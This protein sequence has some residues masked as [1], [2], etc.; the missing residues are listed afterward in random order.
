MDP[1]ANVE[2]VHK[3]YGIYSMTSIPDKTYDAIILAVAHKTFST[4][5]LE[6]LRKEKSVVYDIK[7]FLPKEEVDGRL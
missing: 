4:L 7:A 5:P 1:W 6:S 3:E 2:E